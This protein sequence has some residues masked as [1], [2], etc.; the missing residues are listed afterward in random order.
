MP[1]SIVY[2]SISINI[3]LKFLNDATIQI[4]NK[5]SAPVL[6]NVSSYN[7]CG[8]ISGLSTEGK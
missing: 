7:M 1:S 2:V 3:K 6:L 8:F 5:K 4:R